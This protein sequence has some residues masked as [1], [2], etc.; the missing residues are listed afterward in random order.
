MFRFIHSADWQLG[1]RFSQFGAGGRRRR[2]ASPCTFEKA[3][4]VVQKQ[5]VDASISGRDLLEDNQVDESLVPVFGKIVATYSS[6]A[7]YI[8]PGNH[9]PFTGPGSV[10]Q[11]RG[12]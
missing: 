10:W 12:L 6:V 11:P 4:A 5:P 7:I 3:L 2:Q 1:A 8:L 9:G